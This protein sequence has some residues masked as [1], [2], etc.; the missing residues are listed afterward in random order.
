MGFHLHRAQHPQHNLFW[1][2]NTSP[3][4]LVAKKINI[5]ILRNA[6]SFLEK[7]KQRV[8]SFF[9]LLLMDATLLL[10][11]SSQYFLFVSHPLFHNLYLVMAQ[12][13]F[14]SSSPSSS[15]FIGTTSCLI[16]GG[17]EQL[18]ERRLSE[19]EQVSAVQVFPTR[20]VLKFRDERDRGESV[21]D[22]SRTGNTAG[23]EYLT[24]LQIELLPGRV[25]VCACDA[26]T[27]WMYTCTYVRA[28]RGGFLYEDI[29]RG[30]AE[31]M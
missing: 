29:E 9:L 30:G 25:C 20:L 21:A 19:P 27:A 7:S 28:V 26:H 13:M 3:D 4:V 2:R 18:V 14:T 5:K 10:G 6:G 23:T 16:P 1:R 11:I 8:V 24:A 15:S 12:Q 17:E 31:P 22:Q